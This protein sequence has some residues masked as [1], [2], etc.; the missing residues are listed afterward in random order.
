[1]PKKNLNI[2]NLVPEHLE[3]EIG[4]QPWG[5]LIYDDGCLVSTYATHDCLKT[6]ASSWND[7]FGQNRQYVLSTLDLTIAHLQ[8]WRKAFSAVVLT[9][10]MLDEAT[11]RLA[12]LMAERRLSPGELTAVSHKLGAASQ[13]RGAYA[14]DSP[15]DAEQAE[16]VVHALVTAAF[17]PPKEDK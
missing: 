16:T 11:D 8:R 14:Y 13:A 17:A 1:M 10:D 12:T 9:E 6:L 7:D 5:D 4:E 3:A 15:F 2:A